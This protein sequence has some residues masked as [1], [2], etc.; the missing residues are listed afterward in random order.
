MTQVKVAATQMSC[1]WN[2]PKNI[3]KA[4]KLIRKAHAQGAQIILIQELF[5]TPYFC[6]D[7][8]SAHYSL[9]ENVEGSVLIKYFSALAAELAVVLPLSFFESAH[10]VYYNSLVVINA[11]GTVLN[12]YRKTHIP[13]GPGYQ[14][15]HF[16]TPG[17]TGFQVWDTSYAKIG[18]GICWDQWFPETARCLALKGAEIIFYPTAIGSEPN[19]PEINSQP[20]WTL[21]QQGHAA[22]NMVPIVVSNRIGKEL[23]RYVEGLEIT[24]YGSSFIT[25]HIG[26]IVAE[27]TQTEEAVLVYEFDLKKIAV[28]RSS[29]GLFRDRRPEMYE[30]L[31]TSDAQTRRR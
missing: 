1:S 25:N 26:E 30:T 10:N 22:A 14:E 24:F 28:Q 8:N 29:W 18:V 27:A 23:S 17:D 15:K 3:E 7:Q 4:E 2:L 19:F 5:A 9:A 6:I 13:N 31:N 20:H 16:F 21:V 11:D 12:L